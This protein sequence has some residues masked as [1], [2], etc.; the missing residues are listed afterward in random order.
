[1][2]FVKLNKEYSGDKGQSSSKGN[3]SAEAAIIKKGEVAGDVAVH[4]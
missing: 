4:V 3:S 2:T 1:M